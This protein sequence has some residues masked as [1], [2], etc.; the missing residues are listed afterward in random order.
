[1]IAETLERIAHWRRRE[2]LAV[3]MTKM[4]ANVMTTPEMAR[5]RRR[6]LVLEALEMRRFARRFR[7]G[8][9]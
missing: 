3:E 8:R 2:R 1:M 6:A 7:E 9:C 4:G 5:M